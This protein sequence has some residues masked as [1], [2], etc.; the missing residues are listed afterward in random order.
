MRCP[1]GKCEC[2]HY[3]HFGKDLPECVGQKDRLPISDYEQC[4]WP[5]KIQAPKKDPLEECAHGLYRI[6]DE[7]S[8]ELQIKEVLKKHWPKGD[9]D[10]A[11]EYYSFGGTNKE[12][13]ENALRVGGFIQ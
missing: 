1:A 2:V 13:F 12:K 11:W 5:S 6:I 8:S 3:F 4:P 10:K 9:I 7:Y